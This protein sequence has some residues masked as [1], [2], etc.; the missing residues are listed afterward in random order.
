MEVYCI[1]VSQIDLCAHIFTMI[2]GILGVWIGL[3]AAVASFSI[4]WGT[5]TS[6]CRGNSQLEPTENRRKYF[7]PAD[8]DHQRDVNR[9]DI[10]DSWTPG[11]IQRYRPPPVV[12]ADQSNSR[13]FIPGPGQ[14]YG[15]AT[16]EQTQE[17]ILDQIGA[18]ATKEAS[19][20]P[21]ENAKREYHLLDNPRFG[22]KYPP[23]IQ[24]C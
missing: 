23:W 8:Q 16:M 4:P 24:S 11:D 2:R 14:K 7:F 10:Y 18:L 5:L 17:A 22:P 19:L 21:G 1:S 12:L 9:A 13:Q 15:K 20:F 3:T 6:Q